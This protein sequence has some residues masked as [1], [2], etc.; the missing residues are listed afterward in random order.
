MNG[1]KPFIFREEKYSRTFENLEDVV[2]EAREE[3]SIYR[4]ILE[5]LDRVKKSEP[6]KEFGKR[7]NESILR[8]W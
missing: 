8:V 7:K 6:K 3:L 5:T 2:Q 4:D 1:L